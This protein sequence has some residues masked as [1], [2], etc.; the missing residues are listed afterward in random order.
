MSAFPAQVA[1]PLALSADIAYAMKREDANLLGRLERKGI[2]PDPHHVK[3]QYHEK[4]KLAVRK[5]MPSDC[6]EPA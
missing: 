2:L 5:L 4:G 1:W 3:G 6:F